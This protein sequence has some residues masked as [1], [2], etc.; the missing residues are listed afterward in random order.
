MLENWRIRKTLKHTNAAGFILRAPFDA[1]PSSYRT[2][3]RDPKSVGAVAGA[4]G[5]EDG[6]GRAFVIRGQ[7]ERR[8]QSVVGCWYSVVQL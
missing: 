5:H 8:G 3:A 1:A 4:R 2:R 7:S 6:R